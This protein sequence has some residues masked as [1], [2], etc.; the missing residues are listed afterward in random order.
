MP[1]EC[2]ALVYP[3]TDGRWTGREGSGYCRERYGILAGPVVVDDLRAGVRGSRGVD[4]RPAPCP[5]AALPAMVTS[6]YPAGAE[7]TRPA[8]TESRFVRAGPS[9]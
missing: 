6:P 8:G 7:R 4:G 5:V 1:Y 2:H 3:R 9:E